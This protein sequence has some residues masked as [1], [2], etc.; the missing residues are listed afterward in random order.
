MSSE[1]NVLRMTD[2]LSSLTS[3]FVAY[4]TDWYAMRRQVNDD[5]SCARHF[6]HLSQELMKLRVRFDEQLSPINTIFNPS[7]F[8][9]H[10]F[11]ELKQ[12]IYY[13]IEL[14]KENRQVEKHE[15]WTAIA[16]LRF[17]RR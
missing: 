12:R 11:D 6:L 9:N 14:D 15:R 2:N 16:W 7:W 4:L 13:E 1:K 17:C 10:S 3:L 8:E 5:R